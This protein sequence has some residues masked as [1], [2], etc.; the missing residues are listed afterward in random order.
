[1]KI[2]SINLHTYKK[3]NKILTRKKDS[4]NFSCGLVVLKKTETM[5][6]HI[7]DNKEE[8]L[9]GIKGRLQ[10]YI[11]SKKYKTLHPGSLVYLPPNVK[12]YIKN[13]TSKIAKYIY[14]TTTTK[15]TSHSNT[16]LSEKNY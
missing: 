4:I 9:I 12:H 3:S 8:I 6:E 7:T 1:M 11:N 2:K 14:I 10:V 16:T 15:N 13:T 5:P